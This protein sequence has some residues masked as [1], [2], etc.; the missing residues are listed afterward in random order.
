L[1]YAKYGIDGEF[2]IPPE[3]SLSKE[4]E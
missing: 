3:E 1:N 4:G 2:F